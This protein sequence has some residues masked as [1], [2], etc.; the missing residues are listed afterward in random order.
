MTKNE[1]LALD[2][3]I[4]KNVMGLY[5]AGF[6]PTTSR[7]NAF[8]VLEKVACG[9]LITVQYNNQVWMVDNI[10]G[11][12]PNDEIECS[13]ETLEMA[14]SLFARKYFKPL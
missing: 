10:R 6:S 9:K 5:Y 2:K 7:D 14:I 13:A 11:A 1:K 3:W 4:G 8:E 12:G